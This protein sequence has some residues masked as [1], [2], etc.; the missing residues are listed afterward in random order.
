[1]SKE[2]EPT[3]ESL[4]EQARNGDERAFQKLFDRHSPHLRRRVRR[5]L[6]ALLRRKVAE[7]DV[8]QMTYLRVHQS[9]DRFESRGPGSFRAWIERIV[10]NQVADQLRR[11]VRTAKRGL[12]NEISGPQPLSGNRLPAAQATPSLIAAGHELQEQITEAMARLPADYQLVLKLV[13]GE[14]LTLTEAGERMERSHGAAKQLYARAVARLSR[15]VTD[16]QA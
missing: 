5:Q 2:A 3:D 4:A 6:P 1:M 9:L 7:S 14:G 11:Y 12:A 15:M 13:Q 16:E 8:I 10:E